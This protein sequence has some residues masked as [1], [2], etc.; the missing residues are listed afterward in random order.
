MN[1]S[2]PG[3]RRFPTMAVVAVAVVILALVVFVFVNRGQREPDAAGTD[4][5]G[6]VHPQPVGVDDDVV[7]D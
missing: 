3:A 6:V 1:S 4:D 5:A 7:S 2:V